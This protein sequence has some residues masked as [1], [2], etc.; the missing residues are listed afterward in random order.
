MNDDFYTI[1]DVSLSPSKVNLKIT[2]PDGRIIRLRLPLRAWDDM[3]LTKGSVLSEAELRELEADCEKCEAITK[4][5]SYIAS[6]PYSVKELTIKLRRVGFSDEASREAVKAVAGEGLIHEREQACRLAEWQASYM[7]RGPARIKQAL[8]SR[9]YKADD[10]EAAVESVS[11]E[12]YEAAL[13][14]RIAKCCPNG[15]PANE[16]DK[17][18]TAA[19][20]YRQGFSMSDILRSFEKAE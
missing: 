17:R 3:S 2:G 10:V 1:S 5:V 18:R 11:P 8:L 14:A 20:L 9:G 15:I 12:I 19:A 16:S 7:R 6:A 13:E 4:A